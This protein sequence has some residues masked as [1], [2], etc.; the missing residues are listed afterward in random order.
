MRNYGPKQNEGQG[1]DDPDSRLLKKADA[2]LFHFS[3]FEVEVKTSGAPPPLR[4]LSDKGRQ[5][6]H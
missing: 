3:Q 1:P 6:K 2:A 5:L 4:P